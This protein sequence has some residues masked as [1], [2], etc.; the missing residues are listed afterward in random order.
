[1]S[2]QTESTTH[3]AVPSLHSSTFWQMESEEET[4]KA[5]PASPLQPLAELEKP[6]RQLQT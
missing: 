6:L 1:M 3:L 2:T 4:N 5:H